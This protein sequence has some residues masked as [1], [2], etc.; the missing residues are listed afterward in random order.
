[1]A[2]LPKSAVQAAIDWYIDSLAEP[3]RMLNQKIHKNPELAYEEHIAHDDICYFLISQG[4]QTTSHAYGLL[5]FC[6]FLQFLDK[7][8]LSYASLLG[9]IEDTHLEG[10]QFSWTASVLYFRYIFWSYPAMY[11]TVRLP[12]GK[13]LGATVLLWAAVL[14]CHAA[15]HNFTGLVITPF[16]L[17]AL[18]ASIA[19][20]FSLITGMWYT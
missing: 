3:L 18:E 7:Q 20:G 16:F 2:T 6:Y 17:G 5:G 19:P 12:I 15:C 1:M 14:M 9:M 13:Y 11:L 10:T 8:T 4:I